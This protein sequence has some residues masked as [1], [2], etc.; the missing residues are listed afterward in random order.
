METNKR[1]RY[2]IIS[3]FTNGKVQGVGQISV[4]T[5]GCYPNN[6]RV[7]DLIKPT[8]E[9]ENV[10]IVILNIIELSESDNNDWITKKQN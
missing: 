10:E 5:N 2:F 4:E 1:N 3:Y 6:L 9:D 8:L 7:K